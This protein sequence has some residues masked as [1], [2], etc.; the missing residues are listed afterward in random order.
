[1]TYQYTDQ[2]L[3]TLN[4]GE[5]VYSVNPDY[6]DRKGQKIVT[7]KDNI[8]PKDAT[9]TLTVGDQQFQ[10]IATKSDPKTG[11]D[12]MVCNYKAPSTLLTFCYSIRKFDKPFYKST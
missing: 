11:F 10:V 7:A 5:H 8:N 6:A 9:N 3:N 12:G 1:M 2:Q 4:Q